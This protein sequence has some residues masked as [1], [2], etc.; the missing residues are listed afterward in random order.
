MISRQLGIYIHWPYCAAICPYC[1]FNVYK[2]RGRDTAPLVAAIKADLTYWR[3]QTGPRVVSSIF[4]G[5]GTPSLM[6]PLDV[7]LLIETCSNLWGLDRN[8]EIALEANPTDAE[9]SRF[10][11]LRVAG[12]ERISLGVQALDDASLKSLGRFHSAQE[13]RNAAALARDIFPRL[14]IDLIYARSGQSLAQ[15]EGE[16]GQALTLGPDHISPYQLTIESGTAFDRAVKRGAMAMPDSDLA[17]DFFALTQDVLE[18]AGFEAYEVSNHAK[19]HMNRS[20]HNLIYWTSQDW[21]GVGPGAHGRLGWDAGRRATMA[22]KQPDAYIKAVAS[23]GHGLVE[24]EALTRE[25]VRDE[26]WLM[27]L[28]LKDGLDVSHMVEMPLVQS[29]MVAMEQAGFIWQSNGRI[30]LTVQGRVVGNSVIG[31]LLGG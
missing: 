3:D 2:A 26:F 6:D 29:Q 16:M 7:A 14:S 9:A 28:R 11:Q 17:A 13:A 23:N 20:R 25:A 21:I 24:D 19:G 4:F 15:W 12:I 22:A 1:D 10:A 27:G 18:A 8:V 30:G 31:K 5:G